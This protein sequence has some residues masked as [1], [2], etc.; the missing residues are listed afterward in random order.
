MKLNR[1][2]SAIGVSSLMLGTPAAEVPNDSWKTLLD[3]G[4]A[5]VVD[6]EAK[7]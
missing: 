3:S 2:G 7:P 6:P 1:I 4:V 5:V